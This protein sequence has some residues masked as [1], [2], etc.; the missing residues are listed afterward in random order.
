MERICNNCGEEFKIDLSDFQM[1]WI[2]EDGNLDIQLVCP[3][4]GEE[5]HTFEVNVSFELDY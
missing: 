2:P 5:N 1:E 4:C 3:K